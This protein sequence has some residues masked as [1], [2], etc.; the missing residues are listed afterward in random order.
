MLLVDIKPLAV[1]EWLKQ[2]KL[3]PK[4][5]QNIKAAFHR[6][7]EL[8]MLWELIP[9]QRNP[10]SLVE[11]R[12]NGKR[13]R[14]R[15]ILTPAQFQQ[16]CALLQYPFRTMVTVAMYLGLRVSEIL[17][18]K[19]TDFDF[20]AGTLMVTRGTV[21][22]RIGRVKTDYSKDEMPLDP[23]F[24]RVLLAWREQCPASG[25]GWGFPQSQH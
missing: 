3:S 25:G 14:R 9:A 24:A 1:Q 13:P 19:W 4:T 23:A 22:G 17:A 2:L 10:L 12:G 18:L 20:E 7:M 6:M 5:K 8:A 21:H 15:P 16:L 11:V